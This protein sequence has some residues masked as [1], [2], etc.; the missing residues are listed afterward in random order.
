MVDTELQDLCR[1][2]KVFVHHLCLFT[3]FIFEFAVQ[4]YVRSYLS[5]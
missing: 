4:V 5:Q 1:F 2:K 3:I